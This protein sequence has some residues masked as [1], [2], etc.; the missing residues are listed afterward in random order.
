MS[1]VCINQQLKIVPNKC[2]HVYSHWV[3]FV[4]NVLLYFWLVLGFNCTHLFEKY[5]FLIKNKISE[6]LRLAFV[7]IRSWAARSLSPS[8]SSELTNQNKAGLTG[9]GP[10]TRLK[11]KQ[12][13]IWTVNHPATVDVS[14]VHHC[15]HPFLWHCV[16]GRQHQEEGYWLTRKAGEEN[17]LC[18]CSGAGVH[19]NHSGEKDTEQNAGYPRQ[20]HPL[21]NTL[22]G[23]KSMFNSRLRSLKC[24]TDRFRRYFVPWGIQLFSVSQKG[25]R[26]LDF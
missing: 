22:N 17:W 3:M 10:K 5:P 18:N 20:C 7:Y 13:S 26:E 25:R 9:W 6:V 2:T 24:S 23:Q 21:H 8:G 11:L 4:K 12:Q 14:P 16:L 19:H 15:Q 1:Q